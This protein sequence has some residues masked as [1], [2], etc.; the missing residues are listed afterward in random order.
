MRRDGD[1]DCADGGAPVSARKAGDERALRR[2]QCE[3]PVGL[4]RRVLE[5]QVQEVRKADARRP[6]EA[7]REDADC[8]GEVGDAGREG[9]GGKERIF[10]GDGSDTETLQV[11]ALLQDYAGRRL[12][13]GI[14]TMLDG[15]REDGNLRDLCEVE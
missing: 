7:F 11:G 12:S 4:P 3:A 5:V 10:D 13:G 8:E 14:A 9:R 15:S 1:D 2:V 6:G